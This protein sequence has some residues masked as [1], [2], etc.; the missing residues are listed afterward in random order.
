M[1][2]F[3]GFIQR[4]QML[5]IARWLLGLVF[6]AYAVGKIADPAGFAD[7]I[8]AYR[9]LPVSAVNIFALILPWIELLVGLSLVNAA[10]FE[11]AALLAAILNVVFLAAVAAAIARGIDIECGCFT[12]A[13]SKV[14]W[15]LIFRDTALLAISLIVLLGSTTEAN[16]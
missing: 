1:R 5:R 7:S 14:G 6:I 11:G 2:V 4:P 9:I 10:A 15:E 12:I 3:G 16:S 13:R 8:A